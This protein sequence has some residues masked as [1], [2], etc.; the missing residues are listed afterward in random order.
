MLRITRFGWMAAALAA[1]APLFAGGFWLQMG[2]ADASPEAKAR[3][4]ALVIRATGCHDPATAQISGIAIWTVD[5]NRRSAAL[6]LVPLKEHGAYTVQRDWPSDAAVTLEFVGHEPPGLTTSMLV[7][8]R[9]SSIDKGSA[10]FY[11]HEPTPAE[12]MALAAR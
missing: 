4:A 11:P 8:A 5:G 2:T 10:K 6:K 9:G 12:E 3:N 7:R 1:T